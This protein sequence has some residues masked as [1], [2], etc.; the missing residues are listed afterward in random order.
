MFI[1]IKNNFKNFSKTRRK[2]IKTPIGTYKNSPVALMNF[3][4][5]VMNFHHTGQFSS[6]RSI[7]TRMVSIHQ[8]S[9]YSPKY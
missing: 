4:I 7:F 2:K 8:N 1:N 6:D 5:G 3:T 9:H